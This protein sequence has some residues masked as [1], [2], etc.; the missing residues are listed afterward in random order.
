MREDENDDDNN[1][2]S[3]ECSSNKWSQRQT[4]KARRNR[5]DLITNLRVLSTRPMR[6]LP[7]ELRPCDAEKQQL[8]CP[9]ITLNPERP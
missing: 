6:L 1:G 5:I 7:Q 8:A 3:S 4:I 9:T 2:D